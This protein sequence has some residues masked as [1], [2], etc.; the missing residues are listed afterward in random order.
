MKKFI[1][2]SLA[3]LALNATACAD[4]DFPEAGSSIQVTE[5]SWSTSQ[6]DG[7]LIL[8]VLGTLKNPT[9][10][11]IENL[12]VEA[13]LTDRNGK[14]IDVL[15]EHV[16]GL[17][18]PAGQ[19]V[20]FRLQSSAA[21][22]KNAYSEV[23]AR[24]ISAEAHPPQ[25]P[26]PAPE[27]RNAVFEYL[28]SWVPMVIFIGVWM[29]LARKYSGKGSIQDQMLT[30]ISNQNSLLTKQITAIESIASAANSKKAANNNETP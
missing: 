20:A 13:K 6:N 19:Q 18:I 14:V 25:A 5:A 26:H 21:A 27:E 2:I 30:A 10:D 1:V 24:V 4:H 29:F 7:P 12:V 28:I 11:R 3:L 22:S 9:G 15:T 23:Q 16:Y 17:V 8:T